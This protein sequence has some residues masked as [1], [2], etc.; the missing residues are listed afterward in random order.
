M[1]KRPRRS[2]EEIARAFK[3]GFRAWESI[4]A[5]GDEMRRPPGVR[6]EWTTWRS[7]LTNRGLYGFRPSYEDLGRAREVLV[8]AGGLSSWSLAR[9]SQAYQ[10]LHCPTL[11]LVTK[12]SLRENWEAYRAFRRCIVVDAELDPTWQCLDYPPGFSGEVVWNRY[13]HVVPGRVRPSRV[14]WAA[15]RPGS[16]AEDWGSDLDGL[17]VIP[18]RTSGEAALWI[19]AAICGASRVGV[20]GLDLED[21]DR[22][23]EQRE[24]VRQIVSDYPGVAWESYS[25]GWLSEVLRCQ[26]ST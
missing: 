1:E 13:L 5:R 18:Y 15:Y 9:V 3:A 11:V 4:A 16:P 20:V 6:P 21:A 24:S 7:W 19:A 26:S 23:Q 22:Y 17:R 12:N 10:S 14:W 8:I 25:E 2:R